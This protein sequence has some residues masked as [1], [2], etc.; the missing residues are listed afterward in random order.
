M[1]GNRHNL[2]AKTSST[3]S[4]ASDANPRGA[5]DVRTRMTRHRLALALVWLMAGS[6]GLLVIPRRRT[7][8]FILV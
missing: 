1:L 6:A 5:A 8:S 7:E 3:M 4:L 2:E